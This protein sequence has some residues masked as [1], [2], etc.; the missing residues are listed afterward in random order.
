MKIGT[1]WSHDN[2]SLRFPMRKVILP[3]RMERRINLRF[4]SKVVCPQNKFPASSSHKVVGRK[5]E[6]L[7][8]ESGKKDNGTNQP[9]KK[10]KITEDKNNKLTPPMEVWQIRNKKM[11][12]PD[13]ERRRKNTSI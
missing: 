8:M 9:D 13:M 2:R 10:I 1:P 12:K 3:N 4:A 7:L 5:V 11:I 6:K